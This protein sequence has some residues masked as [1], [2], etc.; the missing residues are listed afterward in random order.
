M[1]AHHCIGADVNV[2]QFGQELHAFNNPLTP[3]LKRS[4]WGMIIATKE[5]SAD[6]SGNN[7][8]IGCLRQLQGQALAKGAS[9]IDQGGF[10]KEQYSFDSVEGRW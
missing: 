3:V 9:L 8:V 10:F 6:A 2:E 5:S 7:V 4:A 1:I